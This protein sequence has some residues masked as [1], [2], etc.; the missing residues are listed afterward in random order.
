MTL[1]TSTPRT[2]EVDTRPRL[3]LALLLLGPLARTLTLAEPR[4]S[5]NPPEQ[6]SFERVEDVELLNRPFEQARLHRSAQGDR[7][8]CSS[9]WAND[10]ADANWA[11][12]KRE[13]NERQTAKKCECANKSEREE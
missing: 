1:S 12:D 4:S 3:P 10:G 13:T 9:N 8:L 5:R 11:R 6:C 2:L 7:L